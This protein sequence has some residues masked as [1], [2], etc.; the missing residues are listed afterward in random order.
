MSFAVAQQSVVK[1]GPVEPVGK[2]DP[3]ER[4]TTDLTE[5]ARMKPDT[6]T[7]TPEN[8]VEDQPNDDDDDEYNEDDEKKQKKKIPLC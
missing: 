7:Y 4:P 6:A 5:G 1:A 3:N 2:T 8:V